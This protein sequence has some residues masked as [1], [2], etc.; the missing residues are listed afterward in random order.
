MTASQELVLLLSFSSAELG[1]H[2]VLLTKKAIAGLER[3]AQLW[4][5]PV[6]AVLE[7]GASGS[8]NLDEVV[9]DR[10]TLPFEVSVVPMGSPAMRAILRNAGMVLGGADYRFNG[11]AAYCRNHGVPYVFNSENTLRTR[12][13]IAKAERKDMLRYA[14]R[15][16]W[17]LQQER[18]FLQEVK[19]AS[20]AQ[21]NGTPSF[22]A[23]AGHAKSALLY[24]D[25]RTERHMLATAEQ[26]Q[27]KAQRRSEGGPLRLLFSGR[28][29]HI[30]GADALPRVARALA[31]R[32]VDFE[33]DIC[34]AG[35]CEAQ[36]REDVV[37]FGLA[38][39]VRFRGVLD[40]QTELAPLV[41]EEIDLFVCCHRQG[42]PSCTYLETLACGV[43]IAGYANEACAGLMKR[44][45]AGVLAP[46]DETEPLAQAIAS[47]W[48]EQGKDALL[49]KSRQALEFASEHT[50]ES[51]FARRIE[52]FRELSS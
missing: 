46:I 7:P 18:A 22:E 4:P 1:P 13:Q 12:W 9:V 36:M 3:Y 23:Y 11:S 26:V 52:H 30:K 5:G 37:R 38:P 25:T 8:G 10:R 45:D 51:T 21:C 28:L 35:P 6:R 47:L 32:G 31:L 27:R 44:V 14:R 24:F 40:F 17:E 20:G 2:D 48:D 19:L 33:L 42:D 29:S 39:R 50:F 43:P 34:G 41:R 16:L 49:K 15:L